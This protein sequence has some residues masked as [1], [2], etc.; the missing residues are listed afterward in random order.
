MILRNIRRVF[1]G[2]L[3]L[4]ATQSCTSTTT[5]NSVPVGAALYLNGQYVGQTP[6]VYSDSKVWGERTNIRLTHDGY[7]DMNGVISRDERFTPLSFLRFCS[8]AFAPW[9]KEYDESHTWRLLQ[10]DSSKEVEV[11]VQDAATPAPPAA[12][13]STLEA[14]IKALMKMR[15]EGAISQ[16]EYEQLRDQAIQTLTK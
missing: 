13:P 14:R 1:T 4:L 15:D 8:I 5:L 16:E 10:I 11:P 7:A 12:K 6:Y 2:A 3:I 9:T